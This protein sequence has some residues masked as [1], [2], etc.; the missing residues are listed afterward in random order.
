MVLA[1]FPSS[2]AARS[3]TLGADSGQLARQ[4]GW[5]TRA[6]RLWA[7]AAV[8]GLAKPVT[9]WQMLLPRA[10]P[11]PCPLLMLPEPCT[12]RP[13]PCTS[14]RSAA[15]NK[16]S[17][18]GEEF[19][20]L[21]G[22]GCRERCGGELITDFAMG[23][24]SFWMWKKNAHLVK[25][26]WVWGSCACLWLNSH[27]CSLC[28]GSS[29]VQCVLCLGSVLNMGLGRDWVFQAES[30]HLFF[31]LVQ[32][33]PLSFS[34]CWGRVWNESWHSPVDPCDVQPGLQGWLSDGPSAWLLF[35][36]VA[37]PQLSGGKLPC[38]ATG[39]LLY[40]HGCNAGGSRMQREGHWVKEIKQFTSPLLV[41]LPKCYVCPRRACLSQWLMLRN[42]L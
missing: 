30:S 25:P 4:E 34:S 18:G 42:Q 29:P 37:C 16:S 7:Q 6:E 1:A 35:R 13:H 26:F 23:K 20:G 5:Q 3:Q 10:W 8:S 31:Q 11:C 39:S 19:R 32:L 36:P 2:P 22:R 17:E 15:E 12:L 38:Q 21:A 27:S 40:C 28:T 9:S 24:K 14:P 41:N 33:L